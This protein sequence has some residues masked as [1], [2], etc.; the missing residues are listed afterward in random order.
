MSKN[1]AIIPAR[2]GSK[3]VPHKSIYPLADKP[4]IAYALSAIF[5]SKCLDRIIVATDDEKIA[6][7]SQ[8]YGAETPY[9]LAKELT[10]DK[11]TIMPVLRDV[12]D[13]LKNHEKYAPELVLLIQPTSPFITSSQIK[14]AFELLANNPEADSVTSVVETPHNLHPFNLRVIEEKGYINFAMPK[15]R[16]L[17]PTKQ[18]KPKR[19]YFGN[20]YIFTPNVVKTKN[21][22]IGDKCLPLV[23]D[24]AS[25][26]D[27]DGPDDFLMAENMIKSKLV[28]F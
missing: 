10:G 6:N 20:L 17:Y 27:V 9:L 26:F 14:Q 11:A 21:I 1:I 13:W 25:A 2:G 12:L 5:E 19:Y 7:V 24:S 16:E 3:T 23:I 28:E 15:E 22:P 8:Q 4:L 18:L